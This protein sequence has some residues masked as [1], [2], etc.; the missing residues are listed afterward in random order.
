MS[1]FIF[2]QRGH[3]LIVRQHKLWHLVLKLLSIHYRRQHSGLPPAITKKYSGKTIPT[4]FPF[5]GNHKS[6]SG[7]H[8]PAHWR[9]ID[10]D[11][12]DVFTMQRKSHEPLNPLREKLTWCRRRTKTKPTLGPKNRVTFWS[13][14]M[15]PSLYKNKQKVPNLGPKSGLIF[16]SNFGSEFGSHSANLRTLLL[17]L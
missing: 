9:F 5:H 12:H 11:A 2:F 7:R 3:E 14:K 17:K 10:V 16:G 1:Q 8:L 13:P 6:L 4:V 15:G